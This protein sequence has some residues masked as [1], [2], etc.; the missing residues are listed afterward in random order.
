MYLWKR[1]MNS[2]IVRN[3]HIL[4]LVALFS[5]TAACQKS[6]PQSE[7]GVPLAF[8]AM[9]EDVVPAKAGAGSEITDAA[10]LKNDSFGIYGIYTPTE[11]DE[12]GTNVFL[13]SAAMEVSHNGTQW[14][15]SPTAYWSIN[16]FYRFRAYHPYSGDAFVVNPSSD[17]HRLM[18]EYKVAAGQEDLLVGF[19]AL[20]ADVMNIQ[21]KVS[22][23]FKHALCA[24]QFKVAFKNS[25]YISDDYT[26]QIT[27]FHLHGIIPTGT[28]V[29]GH[30]DGNELVEEL[31]WIA[32][33]YDDSDYYEWTGS[34]EFGKYNGSNAVTILDGGQGLVF[35]IPQSIS[36]TPEKPTSVHFTTARGGA[37]DHHATLPAVTWEPGKIYTYTLLIEKS[38]IE[39]LI[40]IK[41]W[42]EVQ[43]NENIYI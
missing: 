23:N 22:I 4:L 39:V 43:S 28:L 33:Y 24:L 1:I 18:I 20:E 13:S 29:Y 34:R 32:T 36:S 17:T 25:A 19:T 10:K 27:S 2:M 7:A 37:A 3:I 38:D 42:N 11:D 26:D 31:R 8:S 14:T 6:E 21:K 30:E 16:Q 12:D 35:A 9:T 41:D 5:L 15:Y 40:S